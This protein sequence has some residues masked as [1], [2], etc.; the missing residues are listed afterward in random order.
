M[1]LG[2]VNS[3]HVLRFMNPFLRI[4]WIGIHNSVTVPLN[5]YIQ[6]TVFWKVN[7]NHRSTVRGIELNSSVI[8]V[9]HSSR[10]NRAER[11]SNQ[12][13]DTQTPAYSFSWHLTCISVSL[14]STAFNR[15]I[16]PT[17]QYFYHLACAV[18]GLW[19]HM[20]KESEDII[21]KPHFISTRR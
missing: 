4:P 10:S 16:T 8:A 1:T 13:Q 15:Y 7:I 21:L 11:N 5:L 14:T 19:H 2:S 20:S 9:I 6:I 3:N 18:M 12:N 17:D